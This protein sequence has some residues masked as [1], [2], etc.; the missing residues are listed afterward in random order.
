[1]R[2]DMAVFPILL[3]F[4]NS[5]DLLCSQDY[6][7]SPLNLFK[8]ESGE[9]FSIILRTPFS[10]SLFES[11]EALASSKKI[12]SLTLSKKIHHHIKSPSLPSM[13]SEKYSLPGAEHQPL[14]CNR[15]LFRNLSQCVSDVDS[16]FVRFFKDPVNIP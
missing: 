1:M 16:H 12:S 2:W 5:F 15:D 3:K 7:W 8:K 14:S 6:C 4:Q 13:L 11:K 10:T 9:S